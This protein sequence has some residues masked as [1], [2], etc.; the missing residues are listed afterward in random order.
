MIDIKNTDLRKLTLNDLINDAIERGDSTA[1]EWLKE[2]A[3]KK[4]EYKG[5]DGLITQKCQL[6][7]MFRIKYLEKF[8]GYT[9]KGAVRFAASKKREQMLDDMFEKAFAKIK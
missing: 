8:C 1:L 3:K 4:V 5:R 7:S 6:V 2:E 9:R